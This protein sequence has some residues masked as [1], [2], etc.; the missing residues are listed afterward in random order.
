MGKE[1]LQSRIG[2]NFKDLSLLDLA[3]THSSY[4][5]ESH[6]PRT[7]CNERL[8]FLGDAF[9]DAIIGEELY[10]RLPDVKEGYLTKYRAVIVCEESLAEAARKVGLGENMR[11]GHG[12][13]ISGGRKRD[14]IIA[15]AMESVIG[16]VYLDCG[17]EGAKEFVL[18]L[19]GPRVEAALLGKLHSDYKSEFQEKMQTDGPVAI[20]YDLTREEGPDH[21]K[22]FFVEL[23]AGGKIMGRGSGKSKKEAEQQ[24]A[25]NALLEREEDVL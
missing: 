15:D 5:R 1:E 21:D 22:T 4:T 10:K 3:L 11:M 20:S 23:S 16:A 14:S 9:F 24:A 25:K 8:E 6:M 7:A 18:R 19:F 2:Y 12:E 17:Y 13:I